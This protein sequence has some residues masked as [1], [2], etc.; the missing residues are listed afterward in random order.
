[1]RPGP[2]Q[3]CKWLL[4]TLTAF[5]AATATTSTTTVLATIATAAASLVTITCTTAEMLGI[6][7]RHHCSMATYMRF[8]Y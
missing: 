7:C 8:S 6:L 4:T 1:M 2:A 3:C 5:V